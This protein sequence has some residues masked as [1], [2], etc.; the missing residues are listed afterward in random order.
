[1]PEYGR[2]KEPLEKLS[3]GA[4]PDDPAWPHRASG[5]RGVSRQSRGRS[6][7]T[8]SPASRFSHTVEQE[9]GVPEHTDLGLQAPLLRCG[10]P[11]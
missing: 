2:L 11:S 6:T 7:S 1:M 8:P 9:A 5:Q 10:G 3:P 4:V